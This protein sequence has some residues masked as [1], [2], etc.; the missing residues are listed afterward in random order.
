MT[1]AG[2]LPRVCDSGAGVL[3]Y[4][5]FFDLIIVEEILTD[6]LYASKPAGSLESA[7]RGQI[8]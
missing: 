6:F 7:T 5:S 3:H 4:A 1:L 8:R 2:G